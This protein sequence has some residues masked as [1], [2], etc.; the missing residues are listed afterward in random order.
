MA[1]SS[2]PESADLEAENGVGLPSASYASDHLMLCCDV[3]F[4]V[5]G[6]GNISR[7][8]T[9]NKA[10][11]FTSSPMKASKTLNGRSSAGMGR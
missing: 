10:P 3:A 7:G 2:L 6:N 8:Q 5:S 9:R 4:Q 11:Y 1:V